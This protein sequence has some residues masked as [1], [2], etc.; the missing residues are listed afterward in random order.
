MGPTI[1]NYTLLTPTI[2][3]ITLEQLSVVA[4][5]DKMDKT[6]GSNYQFKSKVKLVL[7]DTKSLTNRYVSLR[8]YSKGGFLLQSILRAWYQ[9][10]HNHTIPVTADCGML[11]R[12][13]S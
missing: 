13:M 1:N 2:D 10:C 8:Y 7:V 12:S 5:S 9:F 11:F 4:R 6:Q 3:S